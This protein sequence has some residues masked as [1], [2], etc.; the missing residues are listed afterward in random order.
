MLARVESTGQLP[1]I[2]FYYLESQCHHLKMN[3]IALS[4]ILTSVS[5]KISNT[6]LR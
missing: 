1:D 6:C 4:V 5:K 2:Y 3:T